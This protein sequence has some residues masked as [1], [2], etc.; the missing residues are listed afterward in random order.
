[1][2]PD[3][4]YKMLGVQP[5][6][7]KP[8]PKEEDYKVDVT[9]HKHCAACGKPTAPNMQFCSK[10]CAGSKKRGGMSSMWWIILFLIMM[11]FLFS[12]K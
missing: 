2:A 12:G 9:T 8:E 1:M 11:F 10:T 4:L 6:E 5:R 3:W 7:A